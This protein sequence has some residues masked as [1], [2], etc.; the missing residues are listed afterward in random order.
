MVYVDSEELKKLKEDLD[1]IQILQKIGYEKSSPKTSD[2][3][4]RD[5]CPI[6][7]GGK[8]KSLSINLIKKTFFCHS[9]EEK[10][11]LIDLYAKA[12]GLTLKEALKDLSN[13]LNMQK[14]TKLLPKQENTP[15]PDLNKLWNG[16]SDTGNHNYL[17]R[18]KIDCPPGIRFGKDQMGNDSVV[19]PF[20]NMNE[21]LKTLQFVND[22]GKYFLKGHAQSGNFFTLGNIKKEKPVYI[23]EGISTAMTVW[24]AFGKEFAV[25]S[26][27]SK[28]NI[29]KV[30]EAIQSKYPGVEINLLC[31]TDIG[32]DQRI[33]L[34]K[35][36][37]CK[38]CVPNFEGMEWK[39]EGKE[40]SDFN[41][42][43]SRCGKG[44][45][46]VKVQIENAMKNCTEEEKTPENL[47]LILENKEIDKNPSCT[48]N[49][50]LKAD[51]NVIR[52]INEWL[53]CYGVKYVSEL[54]PIPHLF[55]GKQKS[56]T[57]RSMKS[58]ELFPRGERAIL[59][60]LGKSGKSAIALTMAAS[61]ATGTPF[62]D[63]FNPGSPSKALFI[64]YEDSP[65]ILLRR[66]KKVIPSY[67]KISQKDLF[68]NL[69]IYSPKTTLLTKERDKRVQETSDFKQVLE[70][71]IYHKPELI[72][73]DTLSK[74]FRF[75]ENSNSDANEIA[76]H[77]Q[78]LT[79][80]GAVV[81]L[82]HHFRKSESGNKTEIDLN[83]IR[84][85]G[86]IVNDSRTILIVHS[87]TKDEI[88]MKKIKVLAANHSETFDDIEIENEWPIRP[89]INADICKKEE[90][91]SSPYNL[92]K[93]KRES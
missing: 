25:V 17:K 64:S 26:A 4:I 44:I 68:K 91:D 37:S 28:T 85:G 69:L 5:F 21:I 81:L 43:I 59:A 8:Q 61:V 93:F 80:K 27:G 2:K 14:E 54:G 62:L 82:L 45:D 88:K 33:G 83:S 15:K 74:A 47:G 31:D 92:S 34:E 35:K 50:G 66:L 90:D 10:G 3:E 49:K 78:Q 60:G 71:V 52:N 13:G 38:C 86:S 36:Y 87:E 32:T 76:Q 77:L 20:Y 19:V 48:V 70:S 22:N 30:I 73:I 23:T 67:N 65:K 51:E 46:E 16:F 58:V 40:P 11:D 53:D 24:E 39:K 75:E 72:I 89:K 79:E 56:L 57:D 9:C 18:K 55:M 41:D 42:L 7:G 84:G 1:P 12:T 29:K 6:H 63:I